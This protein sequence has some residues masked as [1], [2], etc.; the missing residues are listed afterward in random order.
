MPQFQIT[1]GNAN[2][3][4]AKTYDDVLKAAL[5]AGKNP[6]ESEIF[7]QAPIGREDLIQELLQGL[8]HPDKPCNI[9]LLG[10][11]G[12][13][14]TTLL[15]A[16]RPHL[17]QVEGLISIHTQIRD[18]DEN[19]HPDAF[20][21]SLY[22]SIS[23]ALGITEPP[24]VA[25]YQDFKAEIENLAEQWRFLL[26]IDEFDKILKHS[27]FNG[28]FFSKLRQL[29][30]C[31]ECRWGYLTA[32]QQTLKHICDHD[33]VK[34][35]KYWALF[36][37]HR[38]FLELLPKEAV[39]TLQTR[40][41][42]HGFNVY[43]AEKL[44]HKWIIPLEDISGAHPL[45]LR[46]CLAQVW[47]AMQHRQDLN[48]HDLEETIEEHYSQLWEKQSPR[49]QKAL[50]QLVYA[51][52]VDA[53]MI[54]RLQRRGLLSSK[55]HL[56]AKEFYQLIRRQTLVCAEDY[57]PLLERFKK[58]KSLWEPLHKTASIATILTVIV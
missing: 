2:H 22:Q 27:L 40:P 49:R 58:P 28:F 26:I 56:F 24:I 7:E 15:K 41:F 9:S 29:A 45:F 25:D 5:E 35:S 38:Y 52:A 30:D 19:D 44:K 36:D 17:A 23:E 31:P 1:L 54:R 50:C 33:S 21:R 34:E 48:V 39:R 37:D 14:K 47:Q 18:W 11:A 8:T 32:S 16:L 13:G 42:Q 4:P 51:K 10:E 20:F 6:Y 55:Q 12:M 53:H 57:R 3:P 46:L 43:D